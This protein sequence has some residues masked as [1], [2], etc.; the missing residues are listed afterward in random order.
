MKT[1]EFKSNS[2]HYWLATNLSDFREWRDT[3]IC[4]YSRKVLMGFITLLI[5]L[6][7]VGAFCYVF[8]DFIAW[9]VAM[10]VRDELISPFMPAMVCTLVIV[11][12][13]FSYLGSKFVEYSAKLLAEHEDDFTFNAFKSLDDFT[14]NAFKSFKDKYCA[15]VT[16]KD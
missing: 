16:F 14:F 7:I 13:T 12:L 10:I 3:D 2:W 4:T 6:A 1:L 11:V 5:L 9:I 15:K 8:G